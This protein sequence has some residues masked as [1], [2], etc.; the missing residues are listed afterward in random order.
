MGE[1]KLPLRLGAESSNGSSGAKF[2]PLP[3][4]KI[5]QDDVQLPL[6]TTYKASPAMNAEQQPVA[7][8]CVLDA[9]EIIK[10]ESIAVSDRSVLPAD[11]NE[12]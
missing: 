3:F 11:I 9:V 12:Y 10:F 6:H 8:Q 2:T 1:P 4:I 7:A 5:E